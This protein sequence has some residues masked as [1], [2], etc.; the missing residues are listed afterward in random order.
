MEGI[1]RSWNRGRRLAEKLNA[2]AGKTGTADTAVIRKSHSWFT[3][4]MYGQTI[5]TVISAVVESVRTGM[6]A[7]SVAKRFECITIK[8]WGS[9]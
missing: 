9:M 3:V 6:S 8:Y 4:S 7:V 2:V 5:R 1:Y